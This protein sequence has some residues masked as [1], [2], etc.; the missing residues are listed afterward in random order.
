MSHKRFELS[1][2]NALV[3]VIHHNP[4][5]RRRFVRGLA[6]AGYTTLEAEGRSDALPLAFRMAPNLILLEVQADEEE[7]E[8][9]FSRLRAFTDAPIILLAD[10][11]TLSISESLTKRNATLLVQPVPV[12]QV[13]VESRAL[14]AAASAA[15][16][17]L[18]HPK[19]EQSIIHLTLLLPQEVL[20]IDRALQEI[21]D[22]GEVHLNIDKGR[23]NSL[24]KF[25][26]E[27]LAYD[28]NLLC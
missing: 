2:G 25:N 13:I 15:N 16:P 4:R 17:P 9:T 14:C 5:E 8:D 22:C 24:T 12:A 18:L 1:Q 7:G 27:V 23:V 11:G 19:R 20:A 6:Q 21:G 10:K 3:L 28:R 26:T